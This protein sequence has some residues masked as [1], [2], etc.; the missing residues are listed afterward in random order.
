MLVL[1]ES[2]ICVKCR[3]EKPL[4]EFYKRA[5]AFD[6]KQTSC[7]D[8]Y[9]E[10]YY[11]YEQRKIWK[12]ANADHIRIQA[13]VAEKKR[14]NSNPFYRMLRNANKRL[15]ITL[16]GTVNDGLSVDHKVPKSWFLPST[17]I[18]LINH[19]DNL[20]LLPIDIN[21]KKGSKYASPIPLSFYVAVKDYVKPKHINKLLL[22]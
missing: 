7:K 12:E 4:T 6:G 1:M 19:K 13:N 11:N 17:P 20:H 14:Y 3:E 8:C 5:R 22:L 16:G 9:T 18:D 10:A 2:K 15:K 21:K